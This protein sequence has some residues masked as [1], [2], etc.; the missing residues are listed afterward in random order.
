MK[1][2]KADELKK[3][4]VGVFT[5]RGVP[6][7]DAD[8]IADVM[9]HANLRGVESH[10]VIRV[11]HYIRR[12]ENGTVDGKAKL[13]VKKTGPSTATIN[14]NDGYGHVAMVHA[15]KL[16]IELAKETGVGVVAVNHSSHCGAL[17]YYGQMAID[18]GMVCF[19]CTQTDGA[20]VPFGGRKPF[21]GT[22]P[23]CFAGPSETGSP[24]ILDMATSTV[25]GGHIFKARTDHKPIPLG[26]GTDT[27]GNPTTD[28]NK[29]VYF[30]PAGGPKGYGL[31]VVV[32]M[33]TGILS[34]GQFGPHVP[35]MYTR[36]DVK[37]DLAHFVMVVDPARFEGGKTFKARLTEMVNE[38]HEIPPAE[39][40]KS[41]LA[42]GEPEY[43]KQEAR[44]VD[45]VMLE[46]YIWDDII[47]LS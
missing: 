6:A 20:V 12:L 16:A 1:C 45:G 25:A 47:N 8:I 24:I 2:V 26:W 22:N 41:V 18:A 29:A 5:K 7:E 37:R 39:G 30:T 40:F 4:V 44:K 15:T 43:L 42:P 31:G 21:A 38:I 33:L 14:G 19:C 11:P 28:P 9:V 34:G 36:M 3:Q 27:D 17:S 10:G 46:D 32:D 35:G 23:L 13:D